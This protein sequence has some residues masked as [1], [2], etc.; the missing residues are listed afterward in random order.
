LRQSDAA[1]LSR[2][3]QALQEPLAQVAQKVATV[4]QP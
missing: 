2:A 1:K 3:I 4:D